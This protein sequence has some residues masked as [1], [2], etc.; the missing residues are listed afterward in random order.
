MI[1]PEVVWLCAPRPGPLPAP[2]LRAPQWAALTVYLVP[3]PHRLAPP[4]RALGHCLSPSC[5]SCL[6]VEHGVH[7]IRSYTYRA[8]RFP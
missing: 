2:Q 4:W 3:T 6:R 1:S 7:A 5:S 8:G